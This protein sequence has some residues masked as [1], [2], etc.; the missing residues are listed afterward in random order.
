MFW[1]ATIKTSL[2]RKYNDSNSTGLVLPV[3]GKF[4]DVFQL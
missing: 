1:L 2:E 3:L 4:G